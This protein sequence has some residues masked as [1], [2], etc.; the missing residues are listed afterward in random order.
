VKLKEGGGG[1]VRNE[2]ERSQESHIEE[3]ELWQLAQL[4]RQPLELIAVDLEHKL[5]VR[6]R[7]TQF[8]FR[9]LSHTTCFSLPISAG[10]DLKAR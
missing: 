4:G 8:E 5:E 2:I 7:S 6:S 9:T 3:L 1:G 10:I